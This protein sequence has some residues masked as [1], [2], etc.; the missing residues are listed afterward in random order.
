MLY[1]S[2]FLEIYG[3]EKMHINGPTG[4]LSVRYTRMKTFQPSVLCFKRVIY[5]IFRVESTLVR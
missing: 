5:R 4:G 1:F 3:L 2:F